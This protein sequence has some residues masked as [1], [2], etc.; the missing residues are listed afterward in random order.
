M[1]RGA[2]IAIVLTTVKPSSRLFL[3]VEKLIV[4]KDNFDF[5]DEKDVW[6]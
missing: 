2:L 1:S 5:F 3:I 6:R 4:E